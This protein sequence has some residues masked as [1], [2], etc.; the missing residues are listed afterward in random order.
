[1][2]IRWCHNFVSTFVSLV[3]VSFLGNLNLHSL[4]RHIVF[5]PCIFCF[6]YLFRRQQQSEKRGEDT[7]TNMTG[8]RRWLLGR[9]VMLCWLL[10]VAVAHFISAMEQLSA[11]MW[12]TAQSLKSVP[13]RFE[14]VNK[15]SRPSSFTPKGWNRSFS[16]W[17]WCCFTVCHPTSLAPPGAKC[18]LLLPGERKIRGLKGNLVFSQEKKEWKK[19]TL[20]IFFFSSFLG[21]RENSTGFLENRVCNPGGYTHIRFFPL[22]FPFLL[23]T[24]ERCE[25][26]PKKNWDVG[27]GLRWG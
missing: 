25:R 21:E 18:V 8:T 10:L 19:K 6:V 13:H 7:H 4:S 14:R 12:R 11:G 2:M 16:F 23:W 24:S 9:P 22:Y 27:N 20:F 17:W 26:E 1:M 5:N 15:S 3:V